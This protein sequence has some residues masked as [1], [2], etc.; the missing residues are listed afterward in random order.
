[1]SVKVSGF[2]F[3]KHGLSLGYP[4]LESILSIEPL[5]DEIVINVGFEDPNLEKDDGTF[6]HL[7]RNLTHP[8]FIFLKSHWDPKV[9]KNGTILS[10]QTNIALR[11]CTGDICQYI[12]GDEV[13]HEKDLPL[14]H[15]AI[16]ELARTPTMHGLVFDYLHFYGNVDIIKH[17]RNVY[18]R[19]VRTIKNHLNIIS[20]KDAQGFRFQNQQK[21]LCQKTSARIFH[22]GWARGEQIM[23]NKVDQFDKLYHGDDF[24]GK[25]FRYCLLY[26]SPSP[27]D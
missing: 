15:D 26:T 9:H 18:R 23:A 12:Q 6:A 22:Y 21:I 5:C 7:Q 8:K 10:E 16:M 20:W 13:I 2:T 1:M 24:Q 11:A 17:T 4:F 27:R 3:I 14:I 25:R 19:E